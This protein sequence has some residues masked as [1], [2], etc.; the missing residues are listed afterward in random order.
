MKLH[1]VHDTKSVFYNN[2]AEAGPG[3]AY[4]LPTSFPL[5]L[6]AEYLNG[7]YLSG[8]GTSDMGRHYS[9]TRVELTLY[10]SF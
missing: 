1:G 7:Q 6:R 2:I 4:H 5:V 10:K 3:L 8:V 9:N